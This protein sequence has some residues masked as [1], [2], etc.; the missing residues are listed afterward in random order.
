MRVPRSVHGEGRGRLQQ[1]DKPR[2]Y[3][4]QR[5]RQQQQHRCGRQRASGA[6]KATARRKS[7][8]RK[9]QQARRRQHENLQRRFPPR[10]I[11]QHRS[12]SL[13]QIDATSR[14]ATAA[15]VLASVAG[16]GLRQ[17]VL[18]A[19]IHRM[20]P[21]HAL[22]GRHLREKFDD[23][24]HGARRFSAPGMQKLPSSLCEYSRF[25][26]SGATGKRLL[27]H[28]RKSCRIHD[29]DHRHNFADRRARLSGAGKG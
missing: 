18:G 29:I 26:G 28:A 21:W 5:Q 17:V 27:D 15:R 11:V 14:T 22:C 16:I 12:G 10:Q 3:D 8:Q 2:R 20:P 19:Y 24:A 7:G 25:S 4:R 9:Q 13:L 1:R 23:Q 6:R